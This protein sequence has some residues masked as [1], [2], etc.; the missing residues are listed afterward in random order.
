MP[1]AAVNLRGVPVEEAKRAA[2]LTISV[3]G[4]GEHLCDLCGEN[5]EGYAAY[6][7]GPDEHNGFRIFALLCAEHVEVGDERETLV[8]RV[9][10]GLRRIPGAVLSADEVLARFAPADVRRPE[11][12]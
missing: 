11:A 12:S 4:E 6:V 7:T 10:R 8:R 3:L 9:R 1:D 5:I 2:A